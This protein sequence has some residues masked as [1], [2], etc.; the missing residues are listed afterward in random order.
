MLYEALLN[1]SLAM[2]VQLTYVLYIHLSNAFDKVNLHALF[3]KLMNRNIPV[4]L[5]SV[6]EVLC[7]DCFTFVKWFNA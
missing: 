7:S 6:I 3:I 4:E 1:I 5:L 2:L